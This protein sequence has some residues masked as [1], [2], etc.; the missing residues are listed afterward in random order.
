MRTKMMRL[1]VA[2]ALVA[3]ALGSVAV[4]SADA[5]P[6]W[7]FNGT[8]LTG[9]DDLLGAAVSSSMTIP[10]LTT[11]CE[12]FLYNM[13]IENSGGTGEGEITE[14]PLFECHTNTS[15][16]SVEA[17]EAENLPWPTKLMT[18]SGEPYLFIEGVEV[19][20]LYS[21]SKCALGGIEVPVTGTAGGLIDNSTET[22][23]FNAST[24]AATGAK[25]EVGATEIEWNGVFPTE[26]FEWHRED[27]LSVG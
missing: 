10:G 20:I 7:K 8:N 1:I 9:Q 11:T 23:T 2:S 19:I 13:K 18:V 5:A 14:L 17:I 15:A 24:F 12:H 6:A 16:C 3:L 22:A 4:A 21:G 25:L 26:A 27:S